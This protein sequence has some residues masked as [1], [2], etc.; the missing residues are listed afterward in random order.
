M[1]LFIAEKPSLGETIAKFL[2]GGQ[3]VRKERGCI[4]GDG[5]VVTWCF[6]HLYKLYDVEDYFPEDGKRWVIDKLP[7]IP[8]P[9][10]HKP[11][12]RA[13]DQIAVINGLIKQADTVVH[14]GDPDNEGQYLVD[15]VIRYSGYTGPVHRLWLTD[16]SESGLKKVFADIR[17]NGDYQPKSAAAASRSAA[18]WLVGINFTR[19]YTCL[20]QRQGYS[21]MISLGRVQTPT[22]A[23]IYQRCQQIEE[24]VSQQ[25]FDVQAHLSCQNKDFTTQ[26]WNAGWIIPEALLS[27]EGYCLKSD[28]CLDVVKKL[29]GGGV[30]TVKSI[31]RERKNKRADLPFSL[32]KLQSHAS[33][34][35]GLGAKEVLNICQFLYEDMK[36]T[37]YPRSDCQYLSEGDFKLAQEVVESTLWVGDIK[38]SCGAFDYIEKP[39]CYDDK[40]TTAH[41]AIVP[42]G[43]RFD[44][45]AFLQKYSKKDLAAK[46]IPSQEAVIDLYVEIAKRFAAQFMPAYTWVS[47]RVVFD[48]H[49]MDFEARFIDVEALG[50]KPLLGESETDEDDDAPKTTMPHITEGGKV[51]LQG[52]EI[53]NKK[54]SPPA[55]FTEGSLINAMASIARFVDDEKMKRVLREADGLGTEATRADII[56]KLKAVGFIKI[57]KKNIKVLPAGKAAYACFPE[58]FKNPNLTATWEAA[59]SR[60]A[61]GKVD[62]HAFDDSVKK[63]VVDNVGGIIAHPPK[64]DFSASAGFIECPLCKSHMKQIS[65][66]TKFWACANRDC[67]NRVPDY[68][69][70]PMEP[71]PGHGKTCGAC[72]TGIMVTKAYNKEGKAC[73]KDDRFLSCS[74]YPTCKNTKV[75]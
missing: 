25:H 54:T 53:V 15:L 29:Q 71:L 2:N 31:A 60:I 58:F 45:D 48:I 66:A 26:T 18:D 47:S 5:W 24:F 12:D 56:E 73:T 22:F 10:R 30:A 65:A 14:C 1:R 35:F 75:L 39:R 13:K 59:L 17:P 23:L 68:R 46:N 49:N 41:T 69:G 40:K 38:A 11:D 62:S 70:K 51:N 36:V 27:H 33:K 4:K 3:A 57:E 61:E 8:S 63:W 9:F 28:V 55:Y 7:I 20:A 37:T 21:G 32:S 34:K 72:H 43:T 6:G 44:K 42:N 19:L 50:W 64:F 52:G 67:K 74:E 16:L